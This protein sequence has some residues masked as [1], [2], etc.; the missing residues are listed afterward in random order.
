MR[1][2]TT[3][4]ENGLATSSVSPPAFPPAGVPDAVHELAA[5][6][7]PQALARLIEEF[8]AIT[9]AGD[10]V[11]RLCYTRLER[12]AHD[13]F[14]DHMR[15]LGLHVWTDEAGNTYAERPGQAAAPLGALGTGSHLDSVLEAGRFDGI[16][17]VVAAMET[18]RIMVENDA[19]HA[20][21]IRF[22]AFA[23]EEGARFGQ[24]CT[25]SRIA[26]GLTDSASLSGFRDAH[27]TTLSE[28]MKEVGLAPEQV[29]DARWNPQDWA[30]FVELHI[31]QGNV[32]ES[33]DCPIGVVDAISGSTRLR[34]ILTGR[35]SHTG[36]TPMNRRADALAAAA[37]CVLLAERLAKDP[38]HHGTRITVG[39]LDIAPGS[40]T[41]IPG[42]AEMS[43]D[44]RDIDNDR[45]RDTAREFVASARNL[46]RNRGIRM[47]VDEL[48][49][50]SPVILP[51]W[52]ARTVADTCFALGI[53][54]HTMPS[55]ASHDSQ[56][57]NHIVPTGMVF[58][59]SRDGLSHTPAEW[60]DPAELAVG[61]QVLLASLLRLD[62]LLAPAEPVL[63]K[64]A[65]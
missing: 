31:E 35:A 7:D 3:P 55:G 44:I 33:I 48:A 2:D 58:V 8:A 37:E 43:V 41:T 13:R 30:A 50:A 45:Q 57:I 32:L 18:A 20:R 34:L 46:C 63:R 9:E 26:A 22:V 5:R 51:A 14:A 11:T 27:G 60:T 6:V 56:M 39:R 1:A 61:T 29:D 17:G 15:Q 40:I 59:P 52:V 36:G 10:G 12:L 49:D 24:A 38:R 23:A 54:H 28:A 53:K 21:P 65:A 4:R 16:A 19:D 47:E 64:H 62:S 25:G 42:T